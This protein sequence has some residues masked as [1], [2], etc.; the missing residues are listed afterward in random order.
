MGTAFASFP[1]S[2]SA[3]SRRANDHEDSV[4]RGKI[5]HYNGGEGKGLVSADGRQLP[6]EIAQWRSDSAP[7]VNQTVELQ[8]E[9]DTVQSLTRVSE[10]ALLKEKASAFA[11]R[12]GG[13]GDDA[14]GAMKGASSSAGAA[15]FQ[16]GVARLGKPLL[17]I[18]VLFAISALFFTYLKIDPGFGMGRSFSLVGLADI[19]EQFGSSVGGSLLPWFA[20]LSILLPVFWRSRWAWL[21][22]LLPLLATIK[23]WL[24]VLSAVRKA[25]KSMGGLGGPDLGRAMG[26]QVLD[27]LGTGMGMWLCL[28]T[29]LALA[30]FALK[31]TMLP[32]A[33]AMQP[34]AAS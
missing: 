28:L 27:M 9:G 4:M 34:E 1:D 24:D 20:I 8:L 32:P 25:S 2:R 21:A 5:I 31:R 16:A 33:P 10:E 23:P 12:L 11:G 15:G 30:G 17:V 6:F 26:E 14:M 3:R 7:A 19:S 13:I 29:S 22:L 18:H